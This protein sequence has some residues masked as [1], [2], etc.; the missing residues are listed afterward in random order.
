MNAQMDMR[1][2]Q[3]S[4]REFEKKVA[5]AEAAAKKLKAEASAMGEA[6]EVVKVKHVDLESK[7]E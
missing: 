5:K 3:K 2:L 7:V 1:R 6:I 4:N